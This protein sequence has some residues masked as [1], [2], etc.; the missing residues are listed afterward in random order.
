MKIEIRHYGRIRNGEVI[1]D[2]PTL[3]Q[4]QL[5]ELE[6][7]D[8]VM[9]LKKRHE[10]PSRSQ[11]NY[12]RGAILVACHKSDQFKH[13]D[14]KDEIHETYFAPKFLSYKKLVHIEG[15]RP[16]EVTLVRSLTELSKEEVSEFL[17][18]V[19]ADLAN[20]EIECPEP[21]DYYNKYYEKWMQN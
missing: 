13:F 10:K 5:L 9:T 12:Y 20:N 6:G 18:R 7:K 19:L 3:Y 17:E 8:I 1:Y 15:Q 11:Y 4:Q 21:E 14:N 2:I 16:Y